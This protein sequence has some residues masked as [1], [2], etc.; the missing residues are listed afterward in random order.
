VTEALRDASIA[1]LTRAFRRRELSPVELLEAQLDRIRQHNGTVNAFAHVD[2]ARAR[3]AARAS[4]ARWTEGLPLGPLDG[5]TFTAKDNMPVAGW[6]SRR[7]SLTTGEAPM[8]ETAPIV[9]RCEEAGAVLIGSTTMPEFAMGPVTISPL[10]GVT[11]NP[12]DTAMQVGGSSGGAAAASAAGFCSFSL[13]SDAGG[14]IRIPAALCGVP[15][16]KPTGGR[17]PVYP[18]ALSGFLSCHGPIA[19]RVEDLARVLNVAAQPDARDPTALPADGVDYVEAA[20]GDIRGW[21]IALS[22]TLGFAKRLHPEVEAAVRKAARRLESLGAV[23]DERDPQVEDPVETYLV[24]LRGS[25]RYGMR[26]LTPEQRA[27]LSPL[28]RDILEG[29]EVS[30]ADYLRAQ[31]HCVSLARRLQAFHGSYDL[32][33]TPTVAWPAFPAERSYPEEFE[34]FPN[35][36]AW[37]PFTSLFNLT[38]QPAI[39]VPAGLTGG[40]LPIGLHIVGPRG[41]DAKVL[42]A[43]AVHEQA[44]AATEARPS[45]RRSSR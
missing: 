12:W 26:A 21:K 45:M 7:G 32:L 3:A 22:T 2:E 42:R 24:L 41:A 13:A 23:V 10:T 18:P 39:S 19:N 29:P 4:Q 1:E 11:R 5:V 43:A 28:A 25:V 6:P 15:G 20:R 36:R 27:K 14:S 34:A 9:A 17:V 35:R 37:V 38:Q 44:A 8:K 16:F 31:E 30:L 33:L 40:G